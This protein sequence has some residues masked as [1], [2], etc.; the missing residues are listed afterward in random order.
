MNY[1]YNDNTY[2]QIINQD[3]KYINNNYVN[4]NIYDKDNFFNK[5]LY[6]NSMLDPKI[7][8]N[9]LNTQNYQLLSSY[10]NNLNYQY[11][12]NTPFNTQN[13]N[14]DDYMYNQNSENINNDNNLFNKIL[15]STNDK[16]ISMTS[17]IS[18]EIDRQK[19]K[20]DEMVEKAKNINNSELF[21]FDVKKYLPKDNF[22]NSKTFRKYKDLIKPSINSNRNNIFFGKRN[23]N[24]K[25]D[26]IKDNSL[27]E[28]PI[29]NDNLFEEE[30]SNFNLENKEINI[31]N[32]NEINN[33]DLELNNQELLKQNLLNNLD[34]HNLN[35]LNNISN[36]NENLNLN[37]NKNNI[38]NDDEAK[39]IDE[40]NHINNNSKINQ[41]IDSK[42][43]TNSDNL[44]KKPY[45]KIFHEKIN[46]DNEDIGYKDNDSDDENLNEIEKLNI[47]FKNGNKYENI[48]DYVWHCLDFNEE[49]SEN[50]INDFFNNDDV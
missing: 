45:Y 48:N 27:S 33:G 24:N 1:K 43:E 17:Q 28:I 8:Q 49:K 50:I 40:L 25:Y 37:N 36:N 35:D 12:N 34:E 41:N 2:N 22:E 19:M 44:I 9:L 5:N 4:N 38:I 7:N 31:I 20:F 6:S 16:N 46:F 29:R 13:S 26:D 42:N 30:L 39:N 14:R 15:I 23:D 32:N 47:E 10:P 18:Q 21:E 3:R 11:K